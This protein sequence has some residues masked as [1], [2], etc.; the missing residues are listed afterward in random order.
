M[1]KSSALV[2][3]RKFPGEVFLIEICVLNVW[4]GFW[5]HKGS[6]L[7]HEKNLKCQLLAAR[8]N[9][10]PCSYPISFTNYTYFYGLIRFKFPEFL[11]Q[12]FLFMH[13][14]EH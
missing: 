5:Q 7:L 13:I 6:L 9:F 4:G 8:S 2:L 11:G 14:W 12:V 3:R 1:N 10:N